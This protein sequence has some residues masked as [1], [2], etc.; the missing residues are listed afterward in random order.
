MYRP[1]NS[2]LYSSYGISVCTPSE[3]E[4]LSFYLVLD[5]LSNFSAPSFSGDVHVLTDH[6]D[7]LKLSSPSSFS[8]S[9][10]LIQQ[11]ISK[12]PTLSKKFSIHIHWIGG[13]IPIIPHQTV[14]TIA[15]SRRHSLNPLF[16]LGTFTSTC[17]FSEIDSPTL[18]NSSILSPSPFLFP[19]L[20]SPLPHLLTNFYISYLSN[21]SI[22]PPPITL[23][24]FKIFSSPPI[25]PSQWHNIHL[26]IRSLRTPYIRCA[27]PIHVPPNALGWNLYPNPICLPHF[28]TFSI[29]SPVNVLY[30]PPIPLPDLSPLLS[31][32]IHHFDHF[33]KTPL[34]LAFIV[35]N[36][37]TLP[38]PLQTTTYHIRTVATFSHNSTTHHL[39]VIDNF[40]S[41]RL[42]N[43]ILS[44]L[45]KWL[46]Q[47]PSSKMLL[48]SVPHSSFRRS[49]SPPLVTCLPTEHHFYKSPE[50]SYLLPTGFSPSSHDPTLAMLGYDPA[51]PSK[52]ISNSS[53]LKLLRNLY[54][55]HC[56]SY[57][58]IRNSLRQGVT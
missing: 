57:T 9:S 3:A 47:F 48:P 7:L 55:H 5:F 14:H 13:H 26:L 11:C 24:Q 54:R 19:T 8:S 53:T 16:T 28:G 46:T 41:R 29:S 35:P 6:A 49:I 23:D 42:D 40:L 50:Y 32:F 45:S 39:F 51:D 34:R 31:S 17:T 36:N 38:I 15:N 12:Y 43:F 52:Y 30:I 20:Q 10:H 33:S 21:N 2:S 27:H 18:T 1:N 37:P 58:R 25:L 22:Q 56:F 4:F 44:P